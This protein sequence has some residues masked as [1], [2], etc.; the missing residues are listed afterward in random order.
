MMNVTTKKH[1]IT[2]LL[3]VLG[4]LTLISFSNSMVFFAPPTEG[5]WTIDADEVIEG[6]TLTLNVS[7]D[8]ATTGSLT[9]NGST[10][11]FNVTETNDV[12]IIVSGELTI[13]D[14]VITVLN[15]SV[16]LPI[17][18]ESGSSLTIINSTINYISLY[19]EE[20]TVDISGTTFSY[21]NLYFKNDV[22]FSLTDSV[23]QNSAEAITLENV[24]GTFNN[25]NFNNV[26]VGLTVMKTAKETVQF[27]Y[28]N[29]Q[30]VTDT[31]IVADSNHLVE[32]YNSTFNNVD[33][34]ISA[35]KSPISIINS[36]FDTIT[37]GVS[38]VSIASTVRITD[39]VFV[40]AQQGIYSSEVKALVISNNQF[41]DSETGVELSETAVTVSDNDF[42]NL[43]NAIVNSYGQVCEITDNSFD[44]IAEKAIYLDNILNAYVS[45]NT[46]NG[47]LTAISIYSGR[48]N[49]V[50]ENTI[51]NSAL[52]IESSY[53]KNFEILANSVENSTV[54]IYMSET[55]D[56]TIT[57]NGI[58]N[59]SIGISL[60]SVSEIVIASNGVFESETGL[61]FVFSSYSRVSGNSFESSQLA[62][63]LLSSKHIEISDN[64]ILNGERGIFATNTFNPVV[65]GNTFDSITDVAIHFEDSDSFIVYY[66]NFYSI[67]GNNYGNIVDCLGTFEYAI[68]NE[69]TVGNYY[70][71]L[72]ADSVLIDTVTID[73][74]T[75]EIR[76]NHPLDTPYVVK[77]KI[78]YI[79]ANNTE[80]TD[81]D[82]V[83]IT[84]QIF[85]PTGLSLTVNI[86]Y[87]L[88]N[89]TSWRIIDITS[90]ETSI[91]QIGTIKIY[92]G[93]IP[94]MPYKMEITYR[95][96]V[97]YS[98]I[99]IVSANYTYQ[100]DK[101]DSTPI[102]I[103][104]PKVI[105]YVEGVDEDGN[106][107]TT[108]EEVQNFEPVTAYTIVV[109]II[110]QT[111]DIAV[112]EGKRQ[113]FIDMTI[114]DPTEE[115]TTNI[116]DLFFYNSSSGLY[117]YELPDTYVN[118]T[119]ITY[120]IGVEDVNG[121]KYWTI[122][123]YTI[124]YL[125]PIVT[126]KSGFDTL[127]LL[128]IGGML[129]LVQVIVVLRRRRE[130]E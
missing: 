70:D 35:T 100:V 11:T 23:F 120:K 19:G 118:G 54:G 72:T 21:S 39:S 106:V 104:E 37:T 119:V 48:D 98:N 2:A 51:T 1:Q 50:T 61:S 68:D 3:V 130:N 111:V 24:T 30:D 8:I 56:G 74:K 45:G 42:Y 13:I 53:T 84:T 66:N 43:T 79:Q 28:L 89:E 97:T 12:S 64:N 75:Y 101:S 16:L 33:T 15:T 18:L 38:L 80:P 40:N 93:Y 41:N 60:W 44:Q 87:L 73:G 71:G 88:K 52:G 67:A 116:T 27:T 7:I 94:P 124:E 76:D 17:N 46:I 126:G 34:A 125:L 65:S 107:I 115:T 122:D 102:I 78:E 10:L 109:N 57:A 47:T 114:Y 4:F 83:G 112:K 121:N 22:A 31:A 85:V 29:F 69:T 82:A 91:G 36:N 49:I 123:E 117:E 108:A 92:E 90:S 129:F 59:S 86:D 63:E 5:T 58:S 26:D 32:I 20:L 105:Q 6:E 95:I 77:P 103:G 14:S 96:R 25:N 113:V 99:E 110:N 81:E 9:I 62:I 127:S 55:I 128:T